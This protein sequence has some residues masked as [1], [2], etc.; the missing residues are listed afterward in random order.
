MLELTA[1]RA[2]RLRLRAQRLEPRA[3]RQALVETVAAVGGIQAQLAPAMLLALR[4]RIAGL[5]PADVATAIKGAAFGDH[6]GAASGDHGGAAFGDRGGAAFGDRGGAASG[7]HAEDHNIARAWAMRGT[8]HLLPAADIPWLVALLGPALITR[9]RGRR[10]Q[11]GLSDEFCDRALPRIR[12]VL[13][14]DGPLTRWELLDRLAPHGITLDRDSQAP[15]HFIQYA[16]LSGLICLGPDR[17]NGEPTYVLVE[18]WLAPQ[19]EVDR[20]SALA[21]LA[22]RYLR[23]YAPASL[24]DFAAWAGL[25]LREVVKGWGPATATD[26][27]TATTEARVAGSE[28]AQALPASLAAAPDRPPAEP[29]VRLLPAWDDYLLGYADRSLIVPPEQVQSVYRGGRVA[30]VILVDGLV[31][32]TWRHERHGRRL[33]I[34][35]SPFAALSAPVQKGIA[36][37]VDDIGRFLDAPVTITSR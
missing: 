5:T 6:G 3:H 31:A 23:G 4:A 24:R 2:R 26:S 34:Q 12:E 32:G 14:A 10:R 18:R 16:A 1:E 22:R 7:D 35:L 9:G 25:P 28:Q 8:L 27:P 36:D 15:I 11:L 17:P 20:D 29:V 21:L 30:P 37:E 19:P 33:E 13:A